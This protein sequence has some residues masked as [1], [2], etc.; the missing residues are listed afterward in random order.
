MNKINVAVIGLGGRGFGLLKGELLKQRKDIEIT[1][2]CDLFQDRMDKAK[3]LVI[4]R[5]GNTP[6]CSAN[7]KD[8]LTRDDVDI[9]YITSAWEAHFDIAVDSLYA[10]KYTA[11]EVGGAYS[12]DDCWRLVKAYEDTK[13]PFFFLENCC[14]G[15]HELAVIEMVRKGLFGDIV[16][17]SGGYKH[18][19]RYEVAYGKENRHYRLNNY[20]NRNCE[21]YPTH[22]LGPISKLLNINNGNRIVSL[23][24]FASSAKGL[25]DYIIR[26]KSDDKELVNAEFKQG[27]II[28][29]VLKT[30]EGQS[31]VLTLDTTLPRTYSRG[32]CVRGTRASYDEDNRTVFIDGK[33]NIFDN[34]PHY[35]WGNAHKYVK[36]YKHRIWKENRKVNHAMHDGMD[37]LTTLAMIE[38]FRLKGTTP[39]DVYDAVTWMAVTALSEQSIKE[40]GKTM[41]FPDFTNGKWKKREN[42]YK[43]LYCLDK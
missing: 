1:G 19:L 5:N 31:I 18:D 3:E 40:N 29:T 42:K 2:L 27:D 16:H 39:I 7:Y 38:S 41:E 21:N 33:H 20:L 13:T 17:C 4:K 37:T 34:K 11:L 9:I 28:T 12:M 26:K 8:F 14:F 35:I 32:F 43:G 25:H 30:I 22:E 24:S 36:K 15:K 23:N 6:Y 10:G